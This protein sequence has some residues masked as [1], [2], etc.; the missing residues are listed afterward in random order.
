M[1]HPHVHP[2]ASTLAT[3]NGS[4]VAGT[5]HALSPRRAVLPAGARLGGGY[6]FSQ[7][8]HN[9]PHIG[10]GH[11]ASDCEASTTGHD[12]LAHWLPTGKLRGVLFKNSLDGCRSPANR[13]FFTRARS[14]MRPP[15]RGSAPKAPAGPGQCAEGARQG[16]A[17]KAPAGSRILPW[18][19]RQ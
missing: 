2:V 9:V 15:G 14:C 17:L 1:C 5:R 13:P 11:L 12:A 3:C 6:F 16:S 8:G 4:G 18:K 10:Y 19:M 7:I